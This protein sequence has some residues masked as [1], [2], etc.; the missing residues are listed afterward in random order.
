[1]ANL[2]T[3]NSALV[4][5]AVCRLSLSSGGPYN[6][7]DLNEIETVIDHELARLLSTMG[8]LNEPA[9]VEAEKLTAL[10]ITT[11]LDD[12]I[13]EMQLRFLERGRSGRL[14]LFVSY[15]YLLTQLKQTGTAIARSN[16]PFRQ[17][18]EDDG[19]SEADLPAPALSEAASSSATI[20]L[21]AGLRE[22]DALEVEIFDL[23]LDLWSRDEF[24][25]WV[26]RVAVELGVSRADIRR[27]IR[28]VVEGLAARLRLRAK[29]TKFLVALLLWED[30]DTGWRTRFARSRGISPS[31]VTRAEKLLRLTL[32]LLP[33]L[34]HLARTAGVRRPKSVSP[35]KKKA[36][37]SKGM[38]ASGCAACPPR[39]MFGILRYDFRADHE[40]LAVLDFGRAPAT[41][42][43]LGALHNG[44]VVG[45]GGPPP[46]A[47]VARRVTTRWGVRLAWIKRAERHYNR[48]KSGRSSG[49]PIGLNGT[50]HHGIRRWV[51]K[52]CVIAKSGV[53]F[54]EA[55]AA[56]GA[57][58]VSVTAALNFLA[59]RD[60]AP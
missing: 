59:D 25:N 60:G 44:D 11:S 38:R 2:H 16:M 43:L 4:L 1:M 7:R 55:A 5:H 40:A 19:E 34:Q 33:A 32:V 46:L 37:S 47:D 30:R 58:F 6:A 23:A 52:I 53:E 14:P 22:L 18:S 42:A 45:K 20:D 26:Q 29:A 57:T 35:R 9:R 31:T 50:V 51:P 54:H 8:I 28:H 13:Q 17:F 48:L 41:Q 3:L 24:Q 12:L 21:L 27:A 15:R 36:A 10:G 56:L 49:A 39:V